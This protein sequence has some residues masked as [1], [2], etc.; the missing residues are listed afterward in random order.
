MRPS[1]HHSTLVTVLLAA[2]L[3]VLFA[4]ILAVSAAAD[5]LP[6]SGWCRARADRPSNISRPTTT[7]HCPSHAGW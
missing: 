2:I 1:A 7:A 6:T 5:P 3:L 4:D